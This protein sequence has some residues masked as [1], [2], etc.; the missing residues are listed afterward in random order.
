MGMCFSLV[1]FHVGLT[2]FGCLFGFALGGVALPDVSDFWH[3]APAYD[4]DRVGER[5]CLYRLEAEIFHDA[6]ARDGSAA[7]DVH[8]GCERSVVD[9]ERRG[10]AAAGVEVGFDDDAFGLGLRVAGELCEVCSKEDELEEMVDAG[11]GLGGDLGGRYVASEAFE[12]DA[13]FCEV[14]LYLLRVGVRLVD[15]VDGDDV[16]KVVGLDGLECLERLSLH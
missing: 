5:C 15:L 12:V 2:V 16:R 14:H 6:R 1:G 9:Y 10:H 8:A 11:S 3:L 13:L 7:R 4:A